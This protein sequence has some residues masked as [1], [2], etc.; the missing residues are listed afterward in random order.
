MNTD[1]ADSRSV[2]KYSI[3]DGVFSTDQYLYDK[4]KFVDRVIGNW[5]CIR[6]NTLMCA[7]EK[8][9]RVAESLFEIYLEF[10]RLRTNYPDTFK[11][12]I[13]NILSALNSGSEDDAWRSLATANQDCVST[14]LFISRA[15]RGYVD[16]QHID[17]ERIDKQ[18]AIEAQFDRVFQTAE[19]LKIL[20]NEIEKEQD[21]KAANGFV[22]EAKSHRAGELEEARTK[23]FDTVLTLKDLREQL[24]NL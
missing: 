9:E 11:G 3:L 5:N 22:K 21:R 13:G 7:T 19:P 14:A 20:I 12:H 6:F 23:V 24:V 1:F 18:A 2:I 4:T 15:Q 8:H 17:S 16:S 10:R